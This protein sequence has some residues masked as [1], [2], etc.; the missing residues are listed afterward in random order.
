MAQDSRL[1]LMANA[2]RWSQVT[3]AGGFALRYADPLLHWLTAVTQSAETASESLMYLVNRLAQKG[4]GSPSETRL[5]EYL[6]RQ[7]SRIVS[8]YYRQKLPDAPAPE[9]ATP[10]LNGVWEDA[11]RENLLRRSWRT[12]ERYEHA[13]PTKPLFTVLRTVLDL[14]TDAAE[15]VASRLQQESQLAIAPT[16]IPRAIHAS[17]RK[18]AQFLLEETADTLMAP[19]ADQQI[20]ELKRLQLDDWVVPL[21]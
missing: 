1:K 16:D 2:Q 6:H 15:T 21:L 18:F 14:E 8:A 13:N 11:W 20:E 4:F 10:E 17:R 12:L 9:L 5:S 3:S 7:A 19:S